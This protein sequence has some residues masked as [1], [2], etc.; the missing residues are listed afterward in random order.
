M[1]GFLDGWFSV[2]TLLWLFPA[3][4]ML[5]DFE[6]IIFID[7]WY[8]KHGEAIR[9]R[10]PVR[11]RPG[12]ERVAS[13][14]SGQFAVAV[15]VEFILFIP[16]TYA[17]SER[18]AML[19]FLSCNAVLL[20]HVFTHLGQSLYLRRYTPGVVSAVLLT[21]PYT[22]YLFD[23]LI[24]EGVVTFAEIAYSLPIGLLI[25]PIVLA[26]HEL[27]RRIVPGS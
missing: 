22:L 25:V 3:V 8:K 21:T 1:W 13:M 9:P 26:G 20:L 27:G 2:H 17:A 6:E 11:M 10:I 7:G 14:T 16:I 23:R 24:R 15:L 19:L 4:F 5:H 12:F 18:G